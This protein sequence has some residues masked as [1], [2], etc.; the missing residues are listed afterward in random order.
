[1][2]MTKVPSLRKELEFITNHPD[3]WHQGHW[4]ISTP[5]SECGTMGC[6]AGNAVAHCDQ[7]ILLLK[8]DGCLYPERKFTRESVSWQVA[9]AEALGLTHFEAKEMFSGT[10]SLL[11]LWQLAHAYSNGEI[12]IPLDL[13]GF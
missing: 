7:F 3:A 4:L 11:R 2:D 9:G 10:N 5:H 6:L 13:P 12:E 8:E 1:M